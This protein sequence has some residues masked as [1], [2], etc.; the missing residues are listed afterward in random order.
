MKKTR[1]LYI[2]PDFGGI[3][4]YSKQ[5]HREVY[6]K[7]DNY[8]VVDMKV[9]D[10]DNVVEIFKIIDKF[11]PSIVHFEIGGNDWKIYKASKVLQKKYSTIKQIVTIH[12]TG[13]VVA[14]PS[15]WIM[16]PGRTPLLI[17]KKI[18]RKI[19]ENI[20]RLTSMNSW[21]S[22]NN[23][24]FIVLR[25]NGVKGAHY[26]PLMATDE[27]VKRV[28]KS[29]SVHFN[30]GFV[31]FW[32]KN[33]GVLLLVEAFMKYLSG[34]KNRLVIYGGPVGQ[35]DDFSES[36]RKLARGNSNIVL[37]G[38]IADGEI[39]QA[40]SDLD[41]VV[42]PY[43]LDNP[44]GSSAIAMRSA[45][46]GTPIVASEA[47]QL[48]EVLGDGANY[49]S[50]IDDHKALAYKINEVTINYNVAIAKAVKLRKRI[51]VERSPE[52]IAEKLSKIIDSL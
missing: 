48:K 35:E 14:H 6:S 18:I 27:K 19:Y 3:Y 22:Q 44:A 30:I 21:L 42:L 31:G 49:Y 7:W 37:A 8:E 1:L 20:I 38:H 43:Q 40:I 33:K 2:Y 29:V 9:G 46:S 52:V 15:G 39:T 50:P 11:K 4:D 17:L 28:V 26:L 32:S 41:I 10:R 25:E 51:S 12:D 36:I 34:S 23:I 13:I 45:L 5:L 16:P 47:P 24:G